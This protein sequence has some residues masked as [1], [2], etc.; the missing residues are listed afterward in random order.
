VIDEAQN[1]ATCITSI[2]VIDRI[3]PSLVCPEP[4]TASADADCTAIVPL[5]EA[6]AS[7][8]CTPPE[9]I[10]LVQ[11]PP[12]GATIGL[13][14][15]VVTVTATD[16]SG[17]SS[18]CT[19]SITV[20][21]TTPP[22]AICP[23][24]VQA[25]ADDACLGVVPD[26]TGD[27]VV[28]D[29]CSDPL[30]I[31]VTQEPPAGAVLELGEYLIL[32]TATDE[33]GN[34]A[35]C[36]TILEVVDRS[37]PSVSC[38]PETTL[39]IEGECVSFIPDIAAEVVV[40]DNCSEPGAILVTQ[41]PPPGTEVGPGQHLVIVIATD[42]AGN[43]GVC[44]AIVTVI[45]IVPPTIECPLERTVGTNDGCGYRGDIG[46]PVVADNCTAPQDIVVTNDAPKVLP[47]GVSIVTWTAADADG[48]TATCS[49]E[50]TVLDK[51]P[52]EIILIG[53]SPLVV[54]CGTEFVDPGAQALDNCEGDVTELMTT[55]G[56][57]DASEPNVY[58]VF[59]HA[60]DSN[61]FG[62]DKEREVHVVDTTPPQIQCPQNQ[63][64]DC[65]GAWTT[66]EFEPLVTDNC[67]ENPLVECVPPAGSQFPIGTT[68]VICS[69]TDAAGNVSRCQFDISVTCV[70]KQLPGDANQD[71]QID[72][73]D[74][75]RLLDYLFLGNPAEL[76]CGDGGPEDDANTVLLDWG[77]DDLLDISDPI[78]LLSYL[79]VG[80]EPHHL[81][82]E[83]FPIDGCGN[84][85]DA[86][87]K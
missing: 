58:R 67:D 75:V 66:V 71:G 85:C 63:E 69:A 34:T 40:E 4:I 9:S 48:N 5:L 17:N 42:E 61:G 83:C 45:D 52:P 36:V 11:D 78:G 43:E 26:I 6:A 73:S 10:V 39:L 8:N 12:A 13:G 81:G 38:P 35:E 80:G 7:D 28:E 74:G 19:T 22:T 56:S 82:T 46:Q 41:E 65:T 29:N 47:L 20:V 27:V 1:E 87:V 18:Q 21:D 23:P 16:E 49:H 59:Y 79:F 86:F 53:D 14:E 57:V 77:G 33:G 76:P 55:V 64:V 70:G 51:T 15:T 32:V 54:E 25:L 30:S 60:E 3:P 31:T 50:V 72:I 24:Q 2:T 62:S 37:P 84:A 44:D 68:T